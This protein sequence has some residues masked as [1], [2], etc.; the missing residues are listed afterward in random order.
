LCI[1]AERDLVAA[2]YADD[3]RA[4]KLFHICLVVDLLTASGDAI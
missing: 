1:A 2:P 3:R 4:V